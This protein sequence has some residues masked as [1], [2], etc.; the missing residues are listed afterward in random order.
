MICVGGGST[1]E[2]GKGLNLCSVQGAS[3]TPVHDLSNLTLPLNRISYRLV[4]VLFVADRR[5]S[6]PRARGRVLHGHHR[7]FTEVKYLTPW[8]GGGC[9]TTRERVVFEILARHELNR[10]HREFSP[11]RR[12]KLVHKKRT[13]SNRIPASPRP[14]PQVQP[15]ED[16]RA[17][18]EGGGL[19]P[20]RDICGA[21]GGV[22]RSLHRFHRQQHRVAS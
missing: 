22:P 10:T 2:I 8:G 21:P 9:L 7:R 11:S 4:F 13:Q 16:P 15:Q 12:A 14:R 20:A 5:L 19:Q 18:G 3:S 1:D 6:W 17:G